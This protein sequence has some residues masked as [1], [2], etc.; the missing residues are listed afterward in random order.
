MRNIRLFDEYNDFLATQESVSGSGKYVEDI[1]PG[2]AYVR[3]NFSAD[4]YAFYNGHEAEFD[5]YHFGDVIYLASDNTL[6]SVYWTGY[7]PSMGQKVGLI[8]VP[9]SHAE[10]GNARMIAFDNASLQNLGLESVQPGVDD[11]NKRDGDTLLGEGNNRQYVFYWNNSVNYGMDPD[12]FVCWDIPGVTPKSSDASEYLYYLNPGFPLLIS[13]D[14]NPHMLQNQLSPNE[15][16]ALDDFD[17]VSSVQPDAN[18]AKGGDTVLGTGQMNFNGQYYDEG[19]YLSVSPYLEDGTQNPNYVERDWEN[20]LTPRSSVQPSGDETRGGDTLLGASSTAVNAFADWNG[21]A[22]TYALDDNG[23]D[24][25]TAA[26]QYTTTGTSRG[27]WYVGAIGEMGYV[28]SRLWAIEYIMNQLGGESVLIENPNDVHVY[29]Y[30]LYTST[31]LDQNSSAR[32]V[33]QFNFQEVYL[34]NSLEEQFQASQPRSEE[35]PSSDIPS[36]S[37]NLATSLTVNGLGSV[38]P[39]AMI[40]DGQIQHGQVPNAP[41][42]EPVV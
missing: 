3:E 22:N 21:W 29:S 20:T 15:W 41:I 38:R 4:T 19:L 12:G 42:Q 39:M 1:F 2:F 7:T 14:I 18:K 10:D 26:L 24:C 25:A 40:K 27:D 30:A 36:P 8:V 9:T 5:G 31:V 11:G 16:Y 37:F 32:H 17:P 35:Y 33:A 28:S 23:E 13:S 34:D 6:K